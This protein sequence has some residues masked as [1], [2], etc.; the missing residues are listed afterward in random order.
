MGMPAGLAIDATSLSAFRSYV[1]KDFIPEYLLF[2]ANQFG[3]H[4]I[5]VYA[6]GRSTK[7]DYTMP[8]RST[9]RPATQPASSPALISPIRAA[10]TTQPAKLPVLVLPVRPAPMTQ[11]AK[12]PVATT[13]TGR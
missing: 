5:G 12:P 4:K 10:S 7:A 1:D 9:T 11:P 2:V 8:P 3:K 6:F 13:P